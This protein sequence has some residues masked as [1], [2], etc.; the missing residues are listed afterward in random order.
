MK[1]NIY[2]IIVI[3][4][5]LAFGLI[6]TAGISI[7][8]FVNIVAQ[9][10]AITPEGINA[11]MTG[12]NDTSTTSG[13][14]AIPETIVTNATLAYAQGEDAGMTT[15]NST[16]M[17]A[18]LAYAQGEDAEDTGGMTD[19]GGMANDTGGMTDDEG[20]TGGEP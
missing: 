4:S 19:N 2:S 15:D 7:T 5:I 3:S 20:I 6:A 12:Q 1:S 18:T 16:M 17:N 14:T 11:T 9:E 13:N 10:G 8:T